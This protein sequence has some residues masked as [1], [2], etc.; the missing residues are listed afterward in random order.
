MGNHH[1]VDQF[2]REVREIPNGKFTQ[3]FLD[4][5]ELILSSARG[6]TES[7]VT[8]I[9]I[10]LSAIEVERRVHFSEVDDVNIIDRDL[11]VRSRLEDEV[12]EVEFDSF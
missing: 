8:S 10:A 11:P 4:D 12:D 7:E 9:R 2:K 6:N 1:S 3:E 5:W